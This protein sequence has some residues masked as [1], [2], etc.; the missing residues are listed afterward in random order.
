VLFSRFYYHFFLLIFLLTGFLSACNEQLKSDK[1]NPKQQN[2]VVELQQSRSTEESSSA[3]GTQEQAHS[4]FSWLKLSGWHTQGTVSRDQPIRIVFNREIIDAD[5]VGKDASKVMHISPKIEG[6]PIFE[7]RTEIIWIPTKKLNSGETYKVS[8]KPIGLKDISATEAPYQFIFQVIPLEFEI[9]TYGLFPAQKD[10]EMLLKGQLL[11]SDGVAAE[12][13]S[14]VLKA[15]QQGKPLSLEWN[16]TNSGKKHGFTIHGIKRESFATDVKLVWDGKALNIKSQGSK[17]I[18][19]PAI[20]EFKVSQIRLVHDDSINPYVQVSFSD[21]LDSQQNLAGLVKLAKNKYKVQR[22]GHIIKIYPNKNLSGKFKI[23]L[24]AGIKGEKGQVLKESFQQEVLFDDIKPQVRFVGKGSILPENSTLEIPFEAVAATAVEVTAFEIYPDNMRQFLQV[25]RLSGNYQPRRTG[26]YLWRKVIPLT[27]A[28][29]NKWNRY[30]FNVTDM[31][32]HHKGGLLRL[33]LSIRQAFSSYDCP[34]GTEKSGNKAKL[35]KNLEDY[36]VQEPSGWDGISDYEEDNAYYDYSWN[37]RNNPC[38]KAYYKY[39]REKISVDQNFIASNIGLIAKQDATGV[40]HVISTDIRTAEPLTGVD[41]EVRN[42]Q[43]QLLATAQSDGSGFAKIKLSATPFLLIAK[44]F[45]DIAYLKVNAKTAL[46]VSHFDVGGQKIKKGIKGTIYGER[47]VWRPGDAIYLTFVLQNKNKTI[48]EGHPV[49]MKLFDPRGRVVAT[50]TNTQSVGGFYAFKFKT[51]EKAETGRWMAKAYLG[52]STFSKPL[53]IET[54]RPNRLK[55]DL[56]FK[57][58]QTGKVVEALYSSDGTPKGELFS[59]WLHG[60]KANNLKADVSLRFSPKKTSF[61]R[62]ADFTFDDPAR[63]LKSTD[64]MLLEGR[65]DGDGYLVFEKEI[66]PKTKPAGMLKATFTTRVF[67]QGGA[68][69]ISRRSIDYHPYKNYV[70]IKLPKGDT[71]R[72]ML[73]TDKQHTVEIASLSDK[74][75]PVSLDQVQV[76]LYKI[77]WKWWWDKSGETLAEYAD[78][79]NTSFLQEAVISTKDGKGSWNFSIKYPQWGRYLIRACDL[80]GDHCTGKTVYI[81]WPGWAGRAQEQGSGAASRLSFFSDKSAYTVGETAIIQLPATTQGRALLTVETG[82]NILQQRWLE[83]S[84][85]NSTDNKANKLKL[86]IPI[87]AEMSPNAYVHISLLQ[88]HKNK[89]NDRPIR[90]YG[91]IPLQVDDPDTY[92]KP[93][94]DVAEEWKPESTQTINVSETQGKPMNYT[95]AIVD[96]GLLGLTA[97]KTP[98]L[99]RYF[100]SK[101]ALGIKTWDLFDEVIGAYGGKL[102]RMIALGGGDEAELDNEDSK[103]RRFPPVVQF[104]GP[105]HLDAG[106]N[107]EHQ[108]TLPAYLGAVRVMLVAG[109]NGAYGKAQKSVFVRQPLMLQASLPRVLGPGEEVSV[110]LNLFVMSDAIKHVSVTVETDGLLSVVGDKTQNMNFDAIG[111]KIAFIRLKT[112]KQ[113]GKTHLK[114]IATSNDGGIKNESVA[115]VY[116]DIRQANQETTRTVTQVINPGETWENPLKP[117]GIEG[118]NHALLE[119]SS[120]PALNLEKRLRYLIRYPHGCLEQTTS[121]VFPQLYLSNVMSLDEQRKQDIEHHVNRGIERLRRFQNGEGNFNYW[122]GGHDSNEWASVY[123]GHFLIEAKKQGYAVPA[124]LLADWL[125]Y[126]VDTAQSYVA[127]SEKYSHVQAYRLYVLALGGQAQMGAMNRLRESSKLNS[128][129]RWMLASAYQRAS[130]PDAAKSLVQGLMVDPESVVFPD[131]TYSSTLGNLGIQLESLVALNKKQDANVLLERIAE[132]MEGDRYQNTQGIAWA[133]MSVARYLGGDTSHFSAKVLQGATSKSINS[134]KAIA[135]T[136]VGFKDA[137]KVENTSGIKLFATLMNQGVPSAGDEQAIE[138]GLSLRIH[139]ET[140]V[141]GTKGA[142]KKKEQWQAL[143]ISKPVLQGS[144]IRIKVTVSN[145]ARRRVKDIALTIPVAAGM[146]IVRSEEPAAPHNSRD[147]NKV[148]YKD[149]GDDRVHYYFA[150]NHNEMIT[151]KIVVNASY[152]GR[153]YLPAI[154]AEAMY[155]GKQHARQVGHWIDIVKSLP[156]T[157][158]RGTATD[159]PKNIKVTT[160]KAWLYDLSNENFKTKMYLV[161]GD[162]AE[163]LDFNKAED[164]TRWYKVRFQ[165]KKLLEKWIRAET[166]E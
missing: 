145:N 12:K 15:T 61:G 157:A 33:T 36:G 89:K 128:K 25:N 147:G 44:K 158:S 21:K 125:R 155:D 63:H 39:N 50:K 64:K 5:K 108:V 141:A 119:I 35:M 42:Y 163:V 122:P 9:K 165:G 77:D 38:K 139:Y 79:K 104:L 96:E 120:V 114:F 56:T 65:L 112:A 90:L 161:K 67:E 98:D 144:D 97:F 2:E 94:I 107:K 92:L 31:M 14:Q 47:G 149:V 162:E 52:G 100:Y 11:V 24:S 124:D 6:N 138:Q 102:E 76:K 103:K 70:G 150:L 156:E 19:V 73:L 126:Q 49:T 154:N 34:S 111:D 48:P 160:D 59:Q 129:A 110:P 87:T 134:K 151:F 127:A 81:D 8:I 46:A 30:S 71:T 69:S 85:M 99:R 83:F 164:N 143:D 135:S 132:E 78:G 82:S 13:V 101:E 131:N 153:Y 146:E 118:S 45:D 18:S 137:L 80:Q 66:K 26:R 54:V 130:Q 4:A 152:Q 3:P 74:G 27:A 75:E 22:Q 88:P 28:D 37:D 105:F 55:I 133:L 159:I 95:L 58:P 140:R 106:E 142:N 113:T 84:G 17:E 41:L 148:D 123:A 40:L 57:N 116:L 32:K 60:A 51:E 166:T 20:N 136:K 7:S 16:H 43:G 62:F 93:K 117:F 86:E 53:S 115:D 10:N 68:F 91:I 121:S 109:E 72:N 29:P 23:T 1:N